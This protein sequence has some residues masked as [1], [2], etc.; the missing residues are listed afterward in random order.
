MQVKRQHVIEIL[1]KAGLPD[2]ARDAD[3]RLPD[4]IDYDD[5]ASFLAGYGISKD[6]L[7]SRVGGSP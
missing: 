5:A 6:E 4:P 1:Q 3:Q 7:I 2:I